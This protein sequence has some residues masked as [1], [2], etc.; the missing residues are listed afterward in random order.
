M[1]NSVEVI[2]EEAIWNWVGAYVAANNSELRE[3]FEKWKNGDKTPTFRQLEEFSKKINVPIGYF[4]LKNPPDEKCNVLE[5]RTVDSLNIKNPSRNLIDIAFQM[6]DIQ[7]WMRNY[8]INDGYGKIEFV[9]TLNIETPPIKAAEFVRNALSLDKNWYRKIKNRDDAF[10]KI[11]IAVSGTGVLVMQSGN[12]KSNTHQ[13]LDVAEFRAFTLV[14]EYVPLIFINTNDTK[15]GMLF[16]LIHEYVHIC[17][18][19]NGFYNQNQYKR[20]QSLAVDPSEQFCNAVTAEILAP[21]DIFASDWEN[22]KYAEFSAEKQINI[23]AGN[24]RCGEVTIARRALDSGF[25]TMADYDRIAENAKQSADSFRA[26][27]KVKHKESIGGPSPHK[28][29]V[30][31]IDLGFLFALENS[32]K[33]GKTLYTDALRLIGGNV[34]GFEKL[35]KEAR[36]KR[37]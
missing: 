34:S 1:A 7:E 36:G 31:Q 35:C 11:K 10:K 5:Y 20:T 14:D 29:K 18:G 37:Q 16:S 26:A 30:S 27:Q 4:F 24:F 12:I 28:I 23:I 8:R 32:V 13:S 9:G 22:E 6:E 15:G 33:E 3:K 25:I 17:V 21:I 2:V 19:K